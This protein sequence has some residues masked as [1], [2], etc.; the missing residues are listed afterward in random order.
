MLDI[1][2]I[3]ENVDQVKAAVENKN[4]DIDIEKLLAL[5]EE[6]RRI[7]TLL[8]EARAEQNKASAQIAQVPEQE[9]AALIEAVSSVK[10]QVQALE[11]E[12]APVATE[13]AQL[14]YQVPNVTDPAM[15]VGKGEEENVV[16]KEVGE[17]PKMDFTPKEHWEL[18]KELDILDVEK[19]AEVSGARFWYLKG[20]LVRLQFAL[21][22]FAFD[23]LINE[24]IIREVAESLGLSDISTKPFVPMIPP[25]MVRD[26]VQKAIHR[27]FGEQTYSVEGEELNLVASAEHTL[28]PYH[29]NE[30][31]PESE[32]PKR[33]IGYSTA[34][35]REAGTYGKDMK[36]MLRGH[37]FDKTE[38]ESFTTAEA[39]PDEQKLILGLQEYMVAQLGLPYQ[40]VQICTG[41][42]GG[43][44][45]QQFDIECWLPGQDAYRETHTSDYMTDYQTRGVSSYYKTQGGERKLLHTNDATAFS[46]RPLIAIM[47]NYQQADGTIRVPEVLQKYMGGQHV[48]GKTQV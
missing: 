10:E 48:I 11:A 37:Q 30:T 29:M 7:G 6:R 21:H 47:E 13:F 44:D 2:F 24:A 34:F 9:R 45:Y 28:A 26:E 43:P 8:E 41:D 5:D 15:P 35:R 25:V 4:K 22:Q 1:K 17:K 40:V 46:G 23:T 19:A 18:G 16:I 36:G 32:L 3:R 39:G 14:L 33:Y 20:D 27:V 38:M 31:L 12:L 42:T